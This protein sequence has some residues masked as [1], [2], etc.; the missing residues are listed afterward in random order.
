[1]DI[2]Q[3][4][5]QILQALLIPLFVIIVYSC[6]LQVLIYRKAGYAGWEYFV[7][8]Y[9]IMCRLDMIGRNPLLCLII[10]IPI[11]FLASIFSIWLMYKASKTF[12][13]PLGIFLLTIFVPIVGY[14]IWAF[15]SKYQYEGPV[16]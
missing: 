3:E 9:N 12:R 4:V 5:T 16:D 10:F 2:L 6:L 11:P 13:V 1:M 15:S 7:P 8:F 14:S